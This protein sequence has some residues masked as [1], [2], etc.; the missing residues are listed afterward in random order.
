MERREFLKRFGATSAVVLY[1]LY[2][3]KAYGIIPFG[4]IKKISPKGEQLYT[5]SG[6]YTW[7]VPV[8]V[9]SF[10]VVCVGGGGAAGTSYG[11]GSGG[12]GLGYANNVAA[13][14]GSDFK[15]TV[16]TEFSA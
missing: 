10:S 7:T 14:P 11:A 9:K 8:G 15:V 3:P 5:T 1:G 6:V 12:G 16:S 4:F 13:N 2:T